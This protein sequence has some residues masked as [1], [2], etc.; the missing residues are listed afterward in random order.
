MAGYHNFSMSN[1]AVH[2]YSRGRMPLSKW[3][4]SGILEA[5]AE[6]LADMEDPAAETKLALLRRC[7]LA[8]LKAHALT[9]TEW[10]HTSSHYNRTDFFGL[11]EG[12][13]DELT[14][15]MV[16]AW[17]EPGE[18]PAATAAPARKLGRID[19]LVWGGTRKHPKATE[20]TMDD[21]EIEEKGCF[22]IVYRDGA[23]VLKKKIGSTGTFVSYK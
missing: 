8:T 15:E 22:Y 19:Y 23:V 18:K 20:A 13:M 17:N 11:N 1:N 12:N 14:A 16:A 21:V 5:A 4:K 9:C 3:T 10:H 6:Y 7:S 2:A